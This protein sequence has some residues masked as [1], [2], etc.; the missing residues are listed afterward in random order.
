MTQLAGT[1]GRALFDDQFIQDPYPLYERMHAEG[2]V[3]RIGD[4]N[5]YAVTGWEAVIEAVARCDDFSSN[6]TAT[7]M[8]NPDGTVGAFP[9][10]E[11]GGASQILATADD[12]DH[13]LHRKVLVRRLAAKHIRAIESL[14][15]D[16]SNDIWETRVQD[17]RIEWMGAMANR[18]PMMIVGRIIGVP[19]ED[20]E[21]LI[22]WGYA[23]TQFAE[24]L[25]T[26][27]QLNAAGMAVMELSGYINER[28]Q[29][30]TA[31]PGDNL[32]GDLASACAAG[33]LDQFASLAM[34]I[35]LFSAGGESTASLIGSAAWILAT[36]PDIQ[37]Q[38]REQP[39]LL[40]AF[41]EEVLRLESP[42]RGHYR[43]VVNDTKLGGVDLQAGSR[44]LLM[45]GAANRDPRHFEN[46]DQF[47][48]NRSGGKGHLAFGRGAHFCVGAA[49]ARLEATVVLRQLLERTEF[50]HAANTGRWLPSL[51]VRRLDHLELVVT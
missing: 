28:F 2:S 18:L 51:L 32:L 24:G 39:E 7:M 46:P 41:L 38:I 37:H 10:G 35:T 49:L 19:R 12:P 40:G 26:R 43:H 44:L 27:E 34:T 30:A 3:H 25:V 6:L 21:K 15:V 23:A 17:G 14:V 33:E 20:T 31:H 29:D 22:R 50:I 47:R 4:S 11:L 8:R 16:T 5:F 48:L 36:D 9:V 1:L 42:F 13:A 45:W